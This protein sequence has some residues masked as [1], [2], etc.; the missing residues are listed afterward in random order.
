MASGRGYVMSPFRSFAKRHRLRV[1]R[2]EDGEPV[3]QG[4]DGL[5]YEYGS[6]RLGV[7]VLNS[8]PKKWGNRKRACLAAGMELLQDGHDQ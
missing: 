3:I 4:R 8:T 7:I 5:I 1:R 6:D 2:D